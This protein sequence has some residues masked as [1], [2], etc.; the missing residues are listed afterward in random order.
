M[1]TFHYDQFSLNSTTQAVIKQLGMAGFGRLMRI[2]EEC[3]DNGQV[4][5]SWSDWLSTLECT[6]DQFDELLSTLVK[7]EAFTATQDEGVSAPLMLTMGQR[8]R[9]VLKK[10]DP[11]T[12]VFLS[13]AQ[14]SE[15]LAVELAAPAWLIKDPA[16]Q[17]LFRRWCA[18]NVTLAEIQQAAER[19]ALVHDV[20][21]VGLHEQWKKI[22]AERVA[23]AYNRA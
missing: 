2:V 1:A 5:L 9:F 7:L 22:R 14:W 6:R 12:V 11:A 4:A 18:S 20:S 15:W 8:L 13:A 3:T 19:G 21:P 16:S 23:L 17:E 10:P